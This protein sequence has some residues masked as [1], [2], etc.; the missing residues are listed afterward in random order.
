MAVLTPAL[1]WNQTT[2]INLVLGGWGLGTIA[3]V[4]SAQLMSAQE[5]PGVASAQLMSAQ[6]PPGAADSTNTFE[7]EAAIKAGVVKPGE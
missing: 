7:K 4:A 5:P 2:L 1:F 3:G 6:E